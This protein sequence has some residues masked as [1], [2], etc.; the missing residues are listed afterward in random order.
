MT[1]LT[2]ASSSSALRCPS[3]IEP[4][5]P[6]LRSCRMRLTRGSP[7]SRAHCDVSS[8]LQSSMTITWSTKSGMVLIVVP[9]RACSLCAGTT[10]ATT[11]SLYTGC[12]PGV[13]SGWV[14]RSLRSSAAMLQSCRS[15]GSASS[16][17]GGRLWSPVLITSIL[18]HSALR[19]VLVGGLSYITDAGSLWLLHGVL[20]VPLAAATTVAYAVSF[21]VNFGL[22]RSVVFPGGRGMGTQLVRY[23]LLVVANYLVT[24][25]LVLGL[26]GAGL[27]YL[28]AKTVAV[29]LI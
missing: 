14:S 26:S 25:V 17:A 18:R 27:N 2:S 24:L 1:T 7:V 21:A 10:T 5:T 13:V 9:I 4:P 8:V 23:V 29:I 22:N 16:P 3:R 28:A 11:R 12:A 6:V 15:P 19:Y 20:G